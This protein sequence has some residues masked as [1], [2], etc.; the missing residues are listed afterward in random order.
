M[1]MSTRCSGAR[2]RK[3]GSH[4][5][6]KSKRDVVELIADAPDDGATHSLIRYQSW[7]EYYLCDFS[8]HAAEEVRGRAL[9]CA[10]LLL[11]KYI[12]S[13]PGAGQNAF[14]RDSRRIGNGICHEIA[15]I[16]G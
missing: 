14:A 5:G 16:W 15:R 3:V 1:R 2:I 9:L 11:M 8:L 13:D 12:Y 4:F 7:L 10:Y 6:G